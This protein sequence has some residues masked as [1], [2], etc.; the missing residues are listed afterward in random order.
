MLEYRSIKGYDNYLIGNNGKVY[1]KTTQH[2]KIST[3]NHTGKGYLYVDLYKHNRRRRWY[4][5]RN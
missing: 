5:K 1:N 2:D 3:S 4:D